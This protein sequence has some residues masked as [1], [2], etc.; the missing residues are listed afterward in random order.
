MPGISNPPISAVGDIGCDR[1]RFVE[2]WGA[3]LVAPLPR[4][5]G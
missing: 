1:I 5:S 3:R 2:V 4:S